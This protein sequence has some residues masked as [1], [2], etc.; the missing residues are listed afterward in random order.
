MVVNPQLHL[1]TRADGMLACK[2]VERV[3]DTAV[4]RV[5]QRH[6]AEV[7]LPGFD[8]LEYRGDRA[9]RHQFGALAIAVDRREMTVAL[10]RAKVCHTQLRR[11]GTSAADD[12]TKD[13][14]Q[15]GR[16]NGTAIRVADAGENLLL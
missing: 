1:A 13:G 11:Q 12:L 4:G 3:G 8:F 16:R 15:R 6:N 10:C 9:D 5:L 2:V 14:L 7:R